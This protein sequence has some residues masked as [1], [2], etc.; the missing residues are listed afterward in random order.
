ME[1]TNILTQK[2]NLDTQ[3]L[4]AEYY[5]TRTGTDPQIFI[6]YGLPHHGRLSKSKTNTTGITI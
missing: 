2:I 4:I 3:I 5:V 1:E 6:K